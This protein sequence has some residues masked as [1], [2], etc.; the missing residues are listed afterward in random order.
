MTERTPARRRWR[1]LVATAVAVLVV[2]VAVAVGVFLGPRLKSPEQAVADAAPPPASLV[3]ARV[4]RR[5]LAES[6]VLRGTV[7]PGAS[8]KLEV[9]PGLA[10][11]TAVVTDVRA[12]PGEPL[13]EGAV[14]VEVAGAP[15]FGLVLPFPLYRDLTDGLSGP[16][17][18]EVQRALVRLGYRTAVSGTFGAD[19]QDALRRFYAA[20]GYPVPEQAG[21]QT[22]TPMLPRTHV[23]RLDQPGR[24][25]SAIPIAVGAVLSEPAAVLAELDAGS[26]TIT[27]LAGQQ[28]VALLVPGTTA[29][30]VDDVRALTST[31][32]V[33]TVATEPAQGETGAAFPVRLTFTGAELTPTPNHTV[34]VTIGAALDAA[35]VLAVPVTAVYARP[36]GSTFVTVVDDPERT[37][38]VTVRTGRSAGGWVE[39]APER[40]QL[41]VDA[42]VVVGS[43]FRADTSDSA[44]TPGG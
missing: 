2:A 8:I 23:V 31:A 24:T 35:P 20:R 5:V 17:V 34:R 27:A 41:D 38:D 42:R 14:L 26:A 10:G 3:T 29:D 36:D 33:E 37:T 28:Q 1:R 6:V 7:E 15:V 4:E 22:T 44:A 16:D 30:I 9:P 19:T 40:S 39:I 11:P 25:I 32:V 13:R 12:E 43:D 18:R 21:P